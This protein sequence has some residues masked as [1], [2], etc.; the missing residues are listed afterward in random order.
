[1][2]HAQARVEQAQVLGD[3]GDGGDGG[4]ARAARDALFDGHGGR[5]AG[6]SVDGRARE[7]FHELPRVGR[8]R[9][10]ETALALGKNNVEREGGFAGT[11]DAGHDGELAVRNGER[12]ILQV[13]FARA[14]D[15]KF[16]V[17]GFRFT[18]GLI[19]SDVLCRH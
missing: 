8:H 14:D 3:L 16:T 15:G 17:H 5:D 13:V 2:L 19:K 7:L 4:F 6:Q 18:V 1:M 10:H 12:K 9:F 11:G